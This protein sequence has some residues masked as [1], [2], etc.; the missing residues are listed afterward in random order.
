MSFTSA[1]VFWGHSLGISHGGVLREGEVVG[2]FFVVCQPAVCPYQ[3]VWTHSHLERKGAMKQSLNY[4]NTMCYCCNDCV[5]FYM[6]PVWKCLTEAYQYIWALCDEGAV[7]ALWYHCVDQRKAVTHQLRQTHKLTHTYTPTHM[8]Y[9]LRG[10]MRFWKDTPP[11][12][13]GA[14]RDA[15][16]YWEA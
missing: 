15:Q 13:A 8:S 16:R 10:I 5:E 11:Q 6:W 1:Y 9:L 4:L 12:M 2:D 14:C 7:L 3:P